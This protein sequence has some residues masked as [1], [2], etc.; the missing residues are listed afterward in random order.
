M[1]ALTLTRNA[2]HKAQMEHHGKFGHTLGQI[3]NIT[4]MSIINIC[5][6]ACRLKNQTVATTITGFQGIK[7]CIQYLASKTHEPILYPSNYYN[8]SNFI[9]LTWSGN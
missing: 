2:P 7:L 5:Y 4:P 1:S 9:R 6:T 8:G 3:Q